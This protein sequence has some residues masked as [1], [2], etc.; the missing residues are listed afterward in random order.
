MATAVQP[1][2]RLL[3]GVRPSGPLHLG[4]YV[5]VLQQC[6]SYQDTYDCYFVIADLQALSTHLEQPQIVRDSVRE[7]V[8]DCLA[9][10]LDPERCRFVLQSQIPE[11]AELTV[12]L[13]LIVQT[14]ELRRNPTLRAEA[15]A[16]GKG[17]LAEE[18]NEVGFGF[19][20]YP[21][22]QVA[23]TLLFTTTPPRTGDELVVPVGEDQVPHVEF[24]RDVARRFNGIYGDVF[25]E[26]E[27]LTAAIA[28]LPGTDGGSKMGK[29]RRN[30]IFLKDLEEA[31]AEKI[32]GMFSDPL[33]VGRDDPGHPDG[34][35]CFVY[36]EA[37]GWADDD[38]EGRYEDC[39]RGKTDCSDCKEELVQRVRTFLEPIQARRAEYERQPE[40][41]EEVV[42]QGTNQA[43]A[44][45]RRTMESVREAMELTYPGLIRRDP[46]A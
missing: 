39:L 8:L 2:K 18:V 40:L 22:S 20:G 12:Y 14:G 3:S 15:R 41:I 9:S 30:A 21:V 27:P 1:V 46:Q 45:A 28:R 29:S 23:D 43:R 16:L 24:A 31:Y 19:L 42:T 37:F 11:L 7:V 17:S 25:L 5:G 13:Q 4:Q 38:I 44:V 32:R 26:P 33:R 34:C 6:L 35:P 10:G 36:H